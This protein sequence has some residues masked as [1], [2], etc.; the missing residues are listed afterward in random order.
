[1]QADVG[2]FDLASLNQALLPLQAMEIK[3]G[4][5]DKFSLDVTADRDSAG[6]KALMTYSDLQINFFR[7]SEPDKKNLGNDILTFLANGIA[8]K[9]KREN[10][11][12]GILETRV[13]ER[14]AFNYWNRIVTNGALNVVRRGKKIK[15]NRR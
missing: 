5:L 8:I 10:A 11:A 13:K 14:S 15:G 9:N 1:M 2:E 7:R 3:Q 4:H 12:A 6:G